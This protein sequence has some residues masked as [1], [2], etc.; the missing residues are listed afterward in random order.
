ME[1]KKYTIEVTGTYS[2]TT[3]KLL[4]EEEYSLIKELCDVLD[5]GYEGLRIHDGWDLDLGI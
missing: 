3:E 2:A 1:K 5:T 4:S